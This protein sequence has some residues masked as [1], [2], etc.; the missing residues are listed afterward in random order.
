MNFVPGRPFSGD[1]Y[2]S[3]SVDSVCSEDGF[4]KLGIKPKSMGASARLFLG[5]QEDNAPLEPESR[6][7]GPRQ[8]RALN[9]TPL[10]A[11]SHLSRAVAGK[12]FAAAKIH[13][14]NCATLGRVRKLFGHTK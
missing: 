6:R 7:G 14:R 12:A 10:S 1:N 9:A 2:N 3:L 5:A 13:S 4:A 11:R 8:V